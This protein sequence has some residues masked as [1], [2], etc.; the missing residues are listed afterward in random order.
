MNKKIHYKRTFLEREYVVTLCAFPNT[1]RGF[2]FIISLLSFPL[3]SSFFH[4]YLF[5]E[6]ISSSVLLLRSR[7][8]SQ[9]CN[10]KNIKIQTQIIIILVFIPALDFFVTKDTSVWPADC[11]FACG[12]SSKSWRFQFLETCS[13]NTPLLFNV[14]HCQSAT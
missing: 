12:E 4:S 6:A 8:L 7:M 13:Y 5:A 14:L 2:I 9:F 10:N 3:S 11:S 1:S